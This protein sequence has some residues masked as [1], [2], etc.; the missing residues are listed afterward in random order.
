MSSPTSD[1]R[2]RAEMLAE[3]LNVAGHDEIF[4]L[5][6]LD[7]LASNGMRLAWDGHD[8]VSTAYAEALAE[9]I[10]DE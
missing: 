1:Q 8:V 3:W 5:D 10:S 4:G 9:R 7:A 6:L 2:D